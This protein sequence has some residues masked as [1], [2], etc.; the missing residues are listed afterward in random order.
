MAIL[1]AVVF[2]LKIQLPVHRAEYWEWVGIRVL[3]IVPSQETAIVMF[4]SDL[5]AV[6]MALV[7]WAIGKVIRKHATNS[8]RS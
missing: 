4:V 5:A 2:F 1:L 7:G 6:A 8:R 3:G